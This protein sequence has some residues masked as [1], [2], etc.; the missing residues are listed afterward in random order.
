MVCSPGSCETSGPPSTI[1]TSGAT[2]F[3]IAT[4]LVVSSTFQIY[5]PKPITSLSPASAG[6][7]ASSFSTMSAVRVP[8]TNS[9]SRVCPRNSPM[10]ASR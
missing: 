1:T 8:I 7:C 2:R 6:R 9:A 10:L 3:S 4:T 5:T